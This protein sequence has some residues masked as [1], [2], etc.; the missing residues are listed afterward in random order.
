MFLSALLFLGPQVAS[1]S[2]TTV[3]LIVSTAT[4][5]NFIVPTFNQLLVRA[6]TLRVYGLSLIL[7]TPTSSYLGSRRCCCVIIA[8]AFELET[9]CNIFAVA[10]FYLSGSDYYKLLSW[11]LSL[12]TMHVGENNNLRSGDCFGKPAQRLAPF[13]AW[14]RP[15]LITLSKLHVFVGVSSV[16]LLASG[17]GL[18][19]WRNWCGGKVTF[20]PTRLLR[21]ACATLWCAQQS[22]PW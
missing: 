8:F 19:Q 1:G 5:T 13:L 6:H 21:L 20:A 17:A 12:L 10:W 14:R 11:K 3:N 2:W 18:Y 7:S 15:Q 4:P 16:L 9:F 22:A